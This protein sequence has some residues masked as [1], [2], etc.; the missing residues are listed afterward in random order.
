MLALPSQPPEIIGIVVTKKGL[1]AG[2]GDAGRDDDWVSLF[3]FGHI[4][5]GRMPT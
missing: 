3:D 5:G 2:L 1:E 4:S